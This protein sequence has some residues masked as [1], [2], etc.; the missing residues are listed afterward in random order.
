MFHLGAHNNWPCKPLMSLDPHLGAESSVRDVWAWQWLM[1]LSVCSALDI[2]SK[3]M[4]DQGLP[5]VPCAWPAI[6]MLFGRVNAA[7]NS[8]EQCCLHQAHG[9]VYI[10]LRS[11]AIKKRW[12]SWRHLMTVTPESV[13]LMAFLHVSKAEYGAFSDPNWGECP[14]ISLAAASVQS[15]SWSWGLHACQ[16]N[17]DFGK[18]Q[19]SD[20]LPGL[21]TQ[22]LQ[23]TCLW[24]CHFL[25]G[26]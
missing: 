20:P 15:S 21:M 18:A 25:A 2:E 5:V 12:R 8:V 17:S 1:V 26:G 16:G 7:A 23:W 19:R 3:T 6:Q 24:V 22:A 14:T 9:A 13:S 11:L 10:N 4:P